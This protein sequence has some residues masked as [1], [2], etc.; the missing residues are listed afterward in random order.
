MGTEQ[1][2]ALR[3]QAII[4]AAALGFPRRSLA[5]ATNLTPGRVQQIVDSARE[6]PD[7][8]PALKMEHERRQ[9]SRALA[10]L[11]STYVNAQ[12]AG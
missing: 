8:Q 12:D 1:A 4:D 11:A 3:D 7:L 2:R 9:R 5:R 10:E 6:R